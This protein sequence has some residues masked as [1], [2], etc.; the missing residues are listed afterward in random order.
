MT[1]GT[2]GLVP[3]LL[4]LG[5]L[6]AASPFAAQTRTRPSTKQAQRQDVSVSKTRQENRQQA[7]EL[8][9]LLMGRIDALR[10]PAW[11]VR[12]RAFLAGVL[13]ERDPESARQLFQQSLQSLETI[14]VQRSPNMPVAADEIAV[15]ELSSLRSELMTLAAKADPAYAESLAESLAAAAPGDSSDPDLV[16]RRKARIVGSAGIALAKERPE[17]AAQWLEKNLATGVSRF[18]YL[19]LE[20]LHQQNPQLADAT[21]NKALS[22]V[23]SHPNATSRSLMALGSYLFPSMAQA[24]SIVT[25]QADQEDLQMGFDLGETRGSNRNLPNADPDPELVSRYLNL[26]YDRYMNTLSSLSTGPV[27]AENPALHG[28]LADLPMAAMLRSLLS[29]HAPDKAVNLQV[30]LDELSRYFVNEDGTTLEKTLQMLSSIGDPEKPAQWEAEE[31]PENRDSRNYDRAMAAINKGQTAEALDIIDKVKKEG[32]KANLRSALISSQI[33]DAI[34]QGQ[35]DS[36][37]AL[38]RTLTEPSRQIPFLIQIADEHTKRKATEPALLCLSEADQ[39]LDKVSGPWRLSLAIDLVEKFA[40]LDSEHAYQSVARL[41]EEINHAEV[42]DGR[43]TLYR[44]GPDLVI[45]SKLLSSRCFTWL[46]EAD[47]GAALALAQSIVRPETSI[48]A[49]LGVCRAVLSDA[50]KL[51]EGVGHSTF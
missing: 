13:A 44:G 5:L 23:E 47:F 24:L 42:T 33:K 36:A 31:T 1:S 39:L 51:S 22:Y 18:T 6:Q 9:P 7:M 12:L 32:M 41:V 4:F 8:L 35:L 49:Q 30:R 11:K 50:A 26:A 46:A 16:A 10:S 15:W 43:R 20:A 14:P 45:A 3:I 25:S 2:R 27:T 38:A 29:K 40:R 28:I 48:A 17:L 19:T 21:F 37:A 34:K